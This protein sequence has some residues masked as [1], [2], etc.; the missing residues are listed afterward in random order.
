M[1]EA[2]KATDEQWNQDSVQQRKGSTELRN[3][4]SMGHSIESNMS[5]LRLASYKY[6]EPEQLTRLLI[7][8]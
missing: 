6:K 8:T 5:H 3:S 2:S 1:T 7:Q 4:K